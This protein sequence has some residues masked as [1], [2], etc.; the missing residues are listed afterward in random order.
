[1][2]EI[3]KED[4]YKGISEDV[5]DRFD[6]SDYPSNHPSGIPTGCNNK[7]LGCLKMKQLVKL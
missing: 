1:M 6:T 4:F 2:Y 3:K 7:M 5:K